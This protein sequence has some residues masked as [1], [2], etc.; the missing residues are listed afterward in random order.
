VGSRL[1]ELCSLLGC[2]DGDEARAAL[3]GL[4]AELGLE[5]RLRALGVSRGDLPALAR[6]VNEE[7]LA[8]NPRRLPPEAVG[9]VLESIY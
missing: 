3:D 9:R 4:M 1:A 6:S 7:R 5:T 2:R 8:N